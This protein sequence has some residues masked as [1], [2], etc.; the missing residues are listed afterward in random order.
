MILA[1]VVIGFVVGVVVAISATNDVVYYR[2]LY[3]E[4]TGRYDET[5]KKYVA[6]LQALE[7]A[8]ETNKRLNRRVQGIESEQLSKLMAPLWAKIRANEAA[9][10]HARE[11]LAA[12]DVDWT[13]EFSEY[14]RQIVMELIDDSHPTKSC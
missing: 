13:Y 14:H 11:L 5:H 12:H 4:F 8:N 2:K 7:K 9:R 3:K 6:A 1:L 10:K